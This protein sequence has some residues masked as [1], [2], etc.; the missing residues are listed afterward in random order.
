MDS[1]SG[2]I[3]AEMSLDGDP[4]DIFYDPRDRRVFAS[5]GAGFI[6]VFDQVDA[7]Q[8]R[9]VARVPTAAGARTSLWVPELRRFFVAVPAKGNQKAEI[10]VFALD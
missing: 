6:D 8:Y 2:R 5:C 9:Q 7:D 3:I 4:D 10:R 1:G